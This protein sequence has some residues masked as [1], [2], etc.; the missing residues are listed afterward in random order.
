MEASTSARLDGALQRESGELVAERNRL[1][2]LAEDAGGKAAVELVELVWG[3]RASSSES[4]A[5]P[6]TSAATSSRRRAAGPSEAVR[7]STASWTVSGKESEPTA[8]DLGDVERVP[9]GQLVDRVAIG[10]VWKR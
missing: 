9:P 6:G 10:V 1:S 5:F 4:S 7:A 8:Q 3:Y 2:V